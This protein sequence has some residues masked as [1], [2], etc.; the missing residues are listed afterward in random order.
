MARRLVR[1]RLVPQRREHPINEKLL[2]LHDVLLAGHL[3]KLRSSLERRRIAASRGRI[4]SG[5]L[6]ADLLVEQREARHAT[7][8]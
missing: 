2:E 6:L 8:R 1:F 5:S 4:P 3:E 7:L